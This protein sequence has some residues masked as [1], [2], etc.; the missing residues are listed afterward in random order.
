MAVVFG[1]AARGER[2]CQRIP[3]TNFTKGLSP[4]NRNLIQTNVLTCKKYDVIRS[5]RIPLFYLFCLRATI[6]GGG[7]AHQTS[8]FE[9]SYNPSPNHLSWHARGALILKIIFIDTTSISIVVHDPIA[10]I[11]VCIVIISSVF[12]WTLLWI[13]DD[14]VQIKTT[15]PSVEIVLDCGVTSLVEMEIW[16]FSARLSNLR[17]IGDIDTTVL[18][19]VIE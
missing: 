16:R 6:F 9:N 7:V 19:W 17:C 15:I 5:R 2:N 13:I 4:Q 10:F 14:E 18:H 1:A 12:Y 11:W 3:G 8:L